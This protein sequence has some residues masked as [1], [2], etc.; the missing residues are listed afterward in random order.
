M[1]ELAFMVSLLQDSNAWSALS[2]TETCWQGDSEVPGPFMASVQMT[3]AACGRWP[4]K[5]KG[6][7]TSNDRHF[8]RR[9]RWWA[10]HQKAN[11]A[12]KAT[13]RSR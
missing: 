11:R 9:L 7:K 5:S 2:S 12:R 8:I 6:K 3:V 10:A 4:L 13:V 1:G